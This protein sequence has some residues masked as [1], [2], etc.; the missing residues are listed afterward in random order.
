MQAA[1]YSSGSGGCW[2]PVIDLLGC[3]CVDDPGHAG[4]ADAPAD[5]AADA[6]HTSCRLRSVGCTEAWPWAYQPVMAMCGSTFNCGGEC[7]I[8]LLSYMCIVCLLSSSQAFAQ[9]VLACV[10]T[11]VAVCQQQLVFGAL[12]Q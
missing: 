9:P 11:G 6:L 7:G 8:V 4:P 2:H 10:L 12:T 5:A 3:V 1:D